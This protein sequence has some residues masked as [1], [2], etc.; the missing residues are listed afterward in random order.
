MSTP[1]RQNCAVPGIVI[2]DKR[3]DI[4]GLRALAVALVV[5]FHLWPKTLPGGFIGVDIFFVISGYLITAHL[6]REVDRTG[7]VSVTRFWARRIRRLLPA[8]FLVVA[9]C[10]LLAFTVMPRAVLTQNLQEIAAS[11]GYFVN[12]LLAF[13]AVDYLAADNADSL[14][15]HYW[16]LSVEEQFYLVWPL[17]IIAAGFLAAK[18]FKTNRR[19][20]IGIALGLVFA[21]SLAYS[22]VETHLNQPFAYFITPTRAWEFA[23]GGLIVFLPVLVART[24]AV[25]VIR[26]SASWVA[27]ALIIASAFLLDAESPFPGSI[28]LVPVLGVAYL[29]WSGDED[30]VWSPQFVSHSGPIQLIGDTSYAIYLWH[31]PLIIVTPYVL[32]HGIGFGTGVA[33]VI[34]TVILSIATKYLVEDPVRLATGTL[35]KRWP[36]YSFMAS[37]MLVLFG[38]T[39]VT[40]GLQ[41]AQLRSFTE[42][43]EALAADPSSCFGAYAILNGCDDPYV[44]TDTVD[45]EYAIG[46]KW[47]VVR[48]QDPPCTLTAWPPANSQSAI[49]ALATDE[50]AADTVLVVGDSHAQAITPAIALAG[51]HPGGW[52]TLGFIMPGCSG[53]S[54]YDL[55]ASHGSKSWSCIAWTEQLWPAIIDAE[56]DLVVIALRTMHNWRITSESLTERIELLE[57]NDIDVVAIDDPPEMPEGRSGPQCAEAVTVAPDACEFPAPEFDDPLLAAAAATDTPVISFDDIICRDSECHALIGGVVVYFDGHHLSQTFAAT[58][59]PRL[60]EEIGARLASRRQT[61]AW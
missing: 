52:Q 40:G 24:R 4:Q 36:A 59:A 20:V 25:Q 60:T 23:A 19:V 50:N 53:F 2:S 13:N 33:I 38:V 29:I 12:W 45:V 17:L 27:V 14:V 41:V 15:Q 35:S 9:V 21:A 43:I 16:S 11:A 37:G 10:V 44:P 31:W 47:L 34:A 51:A 28:A 1:V 26:I 8:S 46:D 49:C 48:Q 3:L 58:L 61:A 54:S 39:A 42:R 22:I 18:V 55:K 7:T 57:R 5:I 32:H 56:P 6:L 30:A